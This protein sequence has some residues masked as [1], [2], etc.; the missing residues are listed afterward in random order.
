MDAACVTR[1]LPAAGHRRMPWK[2]GGGETVEIAVSP[3]GAGLDG[4][5]WRLSMAAVA[6]DG[7]FS[8]FPGIDRTLAVLTGAGMVLEIAGLGRRILDPA[9]PPLAFPA[10]QPTTA[11][12]VNGP[13]TDLNLMT[14]RGRLVHE[15]TRLQ[16]A[17]PQALAATSD[18]L[19][20][21]CASGH[22]GVRVGDEHIGLA[23]LDALLIAGRP[24]TEPVCE[25]AA[26]GT[27]SAAAIF[28]CRISDRLP[29]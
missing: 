16:V 3:A 8:A 1:F 2:N 28:V 14:R 19:V 24:Q 13:I 29:G 4:F 20:L 17:A 11:R 6:V 22:A 26:D 12:L 9:T 23:P 27:D 15:M 7:P 10:D 25:I 21:L 18:I 5:D